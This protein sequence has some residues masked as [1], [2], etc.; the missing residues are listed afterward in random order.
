[1]EGYDASKH[2]KLSYPEWVELFGQDNANFLA[3]QQMIREEF[4]VTEPSP[5]RRV[6]K[7][8]STGAQKTKYSVT[9]KSSTGK[10]ASV[11]QPS[12][13]KKQTIAIGKCISVEHKHV[14]YQFDPTSEAFSVIQH[15]QLY[16]YCFFGQVLGKT[17]NKLYQLKLDL[18][19]STQNEVIDSRMI[20]EV[21]AVGQEEE[22]YNL[23][24]RAEQEL[25]ELCGEV[26]EVQGVDGV[27]TTKSQAID[28]L[29]QSYDRFNNL[30]PD[31]QAIADNFVMKYGKGDNDIIKW[32]IVFE[33][34][35]LEMLA[36]CR[37]G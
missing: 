5:D 29:K 15:H 27:A 1:V 24:L 14:K 10:A 6:T 33:A 17:N 19:P 31:N 28:Y 3:H 8:P 26:E 9:R 23:K 18:L 21:L 22:A 11:H 13:G 2:G 32:K 12:K 16:K 7:T 34:A 36:P 4:T 35:W 25:I 20:I 30:P 37:D